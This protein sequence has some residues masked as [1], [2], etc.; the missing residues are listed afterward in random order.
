M[1]EELV[2]AYGRWPIERILTLLS[3]FSILML[4]G[5]SFLEHFAYDWYDSRMRIPS[6]VL[7]PVVIVTLIAGIRPRRGT[8]V[9]AIVA[10]WVGALVGVVGIVLHYLGVA[11]MGALGVNAI[12]KGPPLFAPASILTAS[13]YGMII[14]Y[15][16]LRR[17][18]RDHA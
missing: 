4:W 6:Y 7:P 11:R 1:R 16:W 13:A 18:G 12:V 2:E 9:A 10:L 15:W 17:F 3:A 14:L 8:L 5:D